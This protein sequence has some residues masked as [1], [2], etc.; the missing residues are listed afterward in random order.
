MQ[1][2]KFALFHDIVAM[3]IKLWIKYAVGEWHSV[4]MYTESN[5]VHNDRRPAFVQESPIN[6]V[7]V[8]K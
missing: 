5:Y 4:L 7:S 3:K 1:R 8:L 2:N 6:R